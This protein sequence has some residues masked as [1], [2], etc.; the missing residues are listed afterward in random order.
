[1][2]NKNGFIEKSEFSNFFRSGKTK[3]WIKELNQNQ[4]NLIENLFKDQMIELLYL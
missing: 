1:M 3:Q 4:K 2:E